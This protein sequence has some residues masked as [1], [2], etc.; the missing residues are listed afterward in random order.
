MLELLKKTAYTGLGLAFMTQEKVREVAH[1]ISQRA[2]L[3][4]EEGRRFADE[5]NAKSKEA[6]DQFEDKVT[7]AVQAALAKLDVPSKSDLE[8]LE[9]RLEAIEA[10]V[11]SKGSD[12]TADA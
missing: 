6:R 12:A 1:D 11:K 4:E 3:S 9:K 7:C 2:K 10:A 5:L 8:A